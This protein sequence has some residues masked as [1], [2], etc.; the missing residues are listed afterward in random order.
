MRQGIRNIAA[1]T[2]FFVSLSSQ[3]QQSELLEACNAIDNKEKRL[4]CLKELVRFNAASTADANSIKRVKAGFAAIAGAVNSGLSY[5]NYRLMIV[6]PAR[7][8]GVFRQES[9]NT[10]LKALTLL[11]QS[12]TAYNDAERLWRAYIYKSQDGGILF[13]RIL[14]YQLN[15]LSDIINRYNIPTTVV[16]FNPHVQ[17]GTALPIIWSYAENSAKEAFD[18][19]EGREK[20]KIMPETYARP[21]IQPA[22]VRDTTSEEIVVENLAR[23]M[24]CNTH[25]IA[26]KTATRV[27]YTEYSVY[28]SKG[29]SQL[30]HC[31]NEICK[32]VQN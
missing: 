21:D 8:L 6:D 31:S 13:G 25:P 20:P 17:I 1:I 22:P 30:F 19:I 23:D 11:E 14:N 5:E 2:V 29:N 7:E 16:L 18:L 9:P 12:V 10:S 28:C 24:K 27:E 32:P 4:A 15:G 3:A 26:A